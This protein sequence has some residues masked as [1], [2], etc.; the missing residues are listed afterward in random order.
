MLFSGDTGML[1]FFLSYKTTV[2]YS[3]LVCIVILC[4]CFLFY[5]LWCTLSVIESGR[6]KVSFEPMILLKDIPLSSSLRQFRRSA[7]RTWMLLFPSHRLQIIWEEFLVR[8]A[9]NARCIG[10]TSL[11]ENLVCVSFGRSVDHCVKKCQ[12]TCLPESSHL[13]VKTC[14][15]CFDWRRFIEIFTLRLMQHRLDG[16][17]NAYLVEEVA[18]DISKI[19]IAELYKIPFVV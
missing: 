8:F 2:Y 4:F 17:V 15:W 16:N 19:I 1:F 18:S 3:V 6:K 5:F 10:V 7:D 12:L 9:S 13:D 14:L 11:L